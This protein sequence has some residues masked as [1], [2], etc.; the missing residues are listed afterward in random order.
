MST[1]NLDVHVYIGCVPGA[2]RG[3]KKAS[4]LL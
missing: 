3:Q 4:D 1:F 2:S